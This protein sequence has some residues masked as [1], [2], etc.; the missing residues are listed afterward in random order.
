MMHKFHVV[1]LFVVCIPYHEGHE[2]FAVLCKHCG[3]HQTPPSTRCTKPNSQS[4]SSDCLNL[5]KCTF[6]NFQQHHVWPKHFP[7]IIVNKFT[8][9]N[10]IS[11]CCTFRTTTPTTMSHASLVRT[12]RQPQRRSNPARYFSRI[13]SVFILS[14]NL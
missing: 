8:K 11:S 9:C 1:S 13:H 12:C 14:G 7:I 4:D 5:E 6:H 3:M 10:C 2:G